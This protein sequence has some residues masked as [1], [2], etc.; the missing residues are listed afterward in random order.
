MSTLLINSLTISLNGS[1][2]VICLGSDL[3][4]QRT[5]TLGTRR[6]LKKVRNEYFG[7]KES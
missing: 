6:V 7:V 1:Q 4:V 5:E 3:W 2:S